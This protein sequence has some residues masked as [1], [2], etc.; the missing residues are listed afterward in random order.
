VGDPRDPGSLQRT[1]SGVT[2]RTGEPDFTYWVFDDLARPDLPFNIR[3]DRLAERVKRQL[4]S[5]RVQLVP[6]V[7][8]KNCGDVVKWE[9]K[10]VAEG[11]EGV[12]VRA[13]SGHYKQGG[14]E[15]RSTLNEMLVAKLKRVEHHEARVLSVF[16]QM[17][18]TNEATRDA[19]GRTKR[20]TAKAGKVGK[21]VLGGCRV[22]GISGRWEG[23]IYDVGT[24]FNDK[25]RAEL[26]EQHLLMETRRRE[27][28]KSVFNPVVGRIMK[29]QT[30][31]TPATFKAPQFPRFVDWKWEGDL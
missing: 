10:W 9:A 19:I 20:S 31:V 18:N 5:T 2:T 14:A 12:M 15:P 11:Y 26:W 25:Q 21:G 30:G 3:L 27:G 6:Q 22:Q 29:I 13:A 7:V 16:E 17:E 8:A 23:V 1:S 28:R 24:G 4:K